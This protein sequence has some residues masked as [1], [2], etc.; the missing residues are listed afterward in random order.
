MRLRNIKRPFIDQYTYICMRASV[1]SIVNCRGAGG[2]WRLEFGEQRGIARRVWWRAIVCL[3]SALGFH[4]L[5]TT[6]SLTSNSTTK[7]NPQCTDTLCSGSSLRTTLLNL[8]SNGCLKDS[9]MMLGDQA[10]LR[11]LG[12]DILKFPICLPRHGLK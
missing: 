9:S 11:L 3:V 2:F 4:H 7:P 10:Q 12:W 5:F 6:L 8:I 1:E